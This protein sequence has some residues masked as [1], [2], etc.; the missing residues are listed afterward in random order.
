M[1]SMLRKFT[2]QEKEK[3]K[4]MEEEK[5]ACKNQ[6]ITNNKCFDSLSKNYKYMF[7]CCESDLRNVLITLCPWNR[8]F[9]QEQ[10]EKKETKCDHLVRL[11]LLS[12]TDYINQNGKLKLS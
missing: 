7:E 1:E 5:A 3:K 2:E 6:R 8:L 10:M 4:E 11:F 12:I 9:S